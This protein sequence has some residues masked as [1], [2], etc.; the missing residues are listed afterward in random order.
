MALKMNKLY[1]KAKKEKVRYFWKVLL[2]GKNQSS[3]KIR[4][5][6]K[7]FFSNIEEKI[8]LQLKFLGNSICFS[9][10]YSVKL[11]S[12]NRISFTLKPKGI[13]VTYFWK[14]QHTTLVLTHCGSNLDF[15]VVAFTLLVSIQ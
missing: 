14:V 4:G 9:I 12:K 10:Q 3:A 11:A 7:L 5:K 1:S 15:P 2:I 13:H 8:S 6:R